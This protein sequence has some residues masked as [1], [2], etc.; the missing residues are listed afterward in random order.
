MRI[1]FRKIR[2]ERH[3]LAHELTIL[4][5]DGRRESVLCET[6]STL[7]HDFI[8]YAVEGAAHLETGFWGRLA[9]GRTLA[10]MNDRAGLP[11]ADEAAEMA[12]VERFVGALSGATKGV[13]AAKLVA[14]VARYAAGTNDPV[15]R[16]LTEAVVVEAQERL[17]GLVGAWRATPPGAAVELDWPPDA[18]PRV[19]ESPG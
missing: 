12:T 17:R 18:P 1:L 16:W 7:M 4:R 15:P 8:H 19:G 10:E 14:A 3:E 11:A 13:P 2:G 5:P 9:A 6:R